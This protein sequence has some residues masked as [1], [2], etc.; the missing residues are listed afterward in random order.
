MCILLVEDEEL[1][2]EIMTESLRDAGFEVV[3]AATGDQAIA[4][5]AE[6]PR[7]FT[8][9]VTDFNMPGQ[10]DGA[11]IAA[12]VRELA[13]SLPV[14][15]ASGRPEVFRPHWKTALGYTLLAK[16]YR[17]HQLVE[18]ARSLVA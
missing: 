9:L 1:I 14:V 2:R 11:A 15:I 6:R 12:Q 4:L 10:R 5:F 18:L 17:P 3:E 8:L 13:P 16:P 7:H